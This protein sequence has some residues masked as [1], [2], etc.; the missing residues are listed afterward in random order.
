MP[1][2]GLVIGA[3]TLLSMSF[4]YDPAYTGPNV[5]G[6][7]HSH[8]TT[9]SG[10]LFWK[11]TTY[12]NTADYAESKAVTTGNGSVSVSGTNLN[13]NAITGQKVQKSGNNTNDEAVLT[14]NCGY[15]TND[16]EGEDNELASKHSNTVTFTAK[17]DPG[18]QFS[19]WKDNGGTRLS[20][21]NPC[22][23][24][25]TMGISDYAS[26]KGSATN[27]PSD[28]KY[29]STVYYAD[30]TPITITAVSVDR[31]QAHVGDSAEGYAV[32]TISSTKATTADFN[33]PSF[34][35][36]IAGDWEVT[37]WLV[38]NGKI[39]VNYRF[40]P[41]VQGEYDSGVTLTV[42]S[43]AGKS[44]DATIPV[45]VNPAATK[46]YSRLTAKLSTKSAYDGGEIW[47]S[48]T[49]GML[50]VDWST[51]D[52]VVSHISYKT[53][54]TI[55]YYLH[56]QS[57]DPNKYIFV[58]WYST[59]AC[60][61]GDLLSDST[62]YSV[63]ITPTSTD[64]DAPTAQTVYARF[65]RLSEHY[66]EVTALPNKAGLG[67]VYATET[68][69]NNPADSLYSPSGSQAMC[70]VMSTST[71]AV[72]GTIYVHAYP[73]Y[74]YKFDGWFTNAACTGA[75]VSTNAHYAYSAEAVST[76]PVVPTKKTLYAKFSM[77]TPI[78]VTFNYPANG[79]Y[80]A[81]VR[82][83]VVED[84]EYVWGEVQIYNSAEQ[85][86]T[87][88]QQMYPTGSIT[89]TATPVAGMAVKSWTDGSSTVTS[90]S[91]NYTTTVT[92]AKT[93]GVTMGAA[94]P[95]SVE[96]T[97]YSD[98]HD[99][100][101]AAG[102]T[103]TIIVVEDCWIPAGDYTIP[104]G[105]SLLIPDAADNTQIKKS[106]TISSDGKTAPTPF[107][108]V[109]MGPGAE[110]ILEG[111]LG[112]SGTQSGVSSGDPGAGAVIGGYGCLDMSKGGSITVKSTGKLYAFGII[113]GAGN[114]STSGTITVESGGE[115]YE[116]IVIMDLHGGGGTAAIVNGTTAKNHYGVFPFNQFY[117]QNI[118]PRMTLQSGAT[119]KVYYYIYA[120]AGASGSLNFI[121]NTNDSFFEISN[122]S[123]S[124]TK[125]Y[126]YTTDRQ[127]YEMNGN[128]NINA[129]T[130]SINFILTS[131]NITSSDFILP[132]GN[133]DFTLTEGA[134]MTLTND[135]EMLPGARITIAQ[136]ANLTIAKSLYLYDY[137]DW[138]L[139]CATGYVRPI[140]TTPEHKTAADARTPKDASTYSRMGQAE[141]VI[142]G[143]VTVKANGRIYT[144]SGGANIYSHGTGKLIYSTAVP[145][146]GKNLYK[147]YKH[148]GRSTSDALTAEEA[149]DG[150]KAADGQTKIG[151]FK[152]L[153]KKYGA[154]ADAIPCTPAVL[155]NA[156]GS[157]YQTAGKTAGTTV[158]YVNGY[159][160]VLTVDSCLYRDE[161]G[162]IYTFTDEDD[163][164]EVI[165]SS[166]Y[167]K[168][169]EKVEASN[170]LFIHTANNCDWVKV[171]AVPEVALT[172]KLLKDPETN[173]Y[174]QYN[175][176]LDYWEEATSYTVTFKNY[177]NKVLQEDKI[178]PGGVPAY[179]GLSNPVHPDDEIGV[180][181]FI[182]WKVNGEGDTITS[183]SAVNAN[184][185]YIAQYSHTPNVAKVNSL[186]V[187]TYY[188][189]WASAL[190]AVN[191]QAT[192]PTLKLLGDV[193]G[194][195]TEQTISQSMTLDLNGH[196]LS[197]TVSEML[198]VNS[199]IIVTIKDGSGGKTGV[200]SSVGTATSGNFYTMSVAKGKVILENGTL[201]GKANGATV[202]PILIETSGS[203]EME[204]GRITT[205]ATGTNNHGMLVKTKN[206]FI[207]GGTIDMPGA[208]V[209]ISNGYSEAEKMTISGGYIKGGTII[210][211]ENSADTRV[212]VTGGY[213][214]TDA[215]LD[216]LV[217]DSYH[218]LDNEEDSKT[219]YP[220]TVAQ[221]YHV[222]FKNGETALQ[223]GYVKVGAKPA[224][225]G[226]IPTKDADAQYTYA[227]K[228]WIDN[229]LVEY[230]KDATLPV[231]GDADVTY[232][233]TFTA[234]LKSYTLA[235]DLNG[236]SVT[237]SGT[238][239]GSVAFGTSLTA[240][241][242]ERTGYIFKGWSPTV[243]ATMPAKD[244][245][246]TA[247]W[248]PAETGDYLDIVDWTENSL[249]INTNALAASGWP[250]TINDVEY[251]KTA[252]LEDRTLIIPYSGS[253]DGVLDITVNNKNSE[254]VSKRSY[255]IPHIYDTDANLSGVNENS[256]V[257][258]H[259]GAIVTVATNTN[260][261]AI[262][263]APN[264]D[265]VVSNGFTLTLADKLV[266]RTTPWAAAALDNRGTISG[267]QVYYSY[268]IANKDQQYYQFAMP[269]A[270]NTNNVKTS[271]DIVNNRATEYPYNTAWLMKYY[272]E[273][274]R[275]NNGATGKNWVALAPGTI[276]GTVGYELFSMSK[277]YREYY[278]PI[279][280][281][282]I[283]ATTVTVQYT[284]GS[285][286]A[287]NGWNAV[288]SPMTKEFR[289]VFANPSKAVKVSELM[290]DGRYYQHIPTTIRPAVP[291]YYQASQGQTQLVFGSEMTA[292]APYRAIDNEEVATEWLQVHYSDA[293]G[294][295]D[296][297]N[298]FLHP[299]DFVAEYENGLD[300]A[301]LS[302]TGARPFLYTSLACGDL[303]F[304][305]L[306]DEAAQRIPL[307]VYSPANGAYT[308]SLTDN[309]YMDRMDA[310]YLVDEQMGIYTDLLS[311]G[312]YSVAVEQGTTTG[313]FYLMA[314]FA[315]APGVAT[316]MDEAEG[317]ESMTIEKVFIDGLF[318]IRRGGE[319][320]DL[321][322]RLVK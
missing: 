103:K 234:T 112:L 65:I 276:S 149:Y 228:G 135:V 23:E 190:A 106:P 122:D 199:A 256:I 168:A 4:P 120:Q 134:N 192:N 27:Y 281:P 97:T 151:D 33:T 40:L 158:R 307:T 176:T 140:T 278:F 36:T 178:Y 147:I 174:Y 45:T 280:L 85:T 35:A 129:I 152:F 250:Y 274:S 139:Y 196:T 285:N 63:D 309:D 254:T 259:S 43:K 238:A 72:N 216:L 148:Y 313:R 76:D 56:A 267:G 270:S 1:L 212:N 169:W 269:L 170:V 102:S 218:I 210:N 310:V 227:F 246:Y 153:N 48:K 255:T 88:T 211:S 204:G 67:M 165:A 69:G 183:F 104:N 177:N 46:Y 257:Y 162:H 86:D 2:I 272:S 220:Y 11:E 185:T 15:N 66:L 83:V 290:E 28:N 10:I 279:T 77:A 260:V 286:A 186:G 75:A 145:V 70:E 242:V 248:T 207:K 223:E 74:G 13:S 60:A 12:H 195:S 214:S 32:F 203:F 55:T 287:D 73:K 156:N 121:S 79:T 219:T 133:F 107:R 252:R 62:D 292:S 44:A 197:G 299:T 42:V 198:K 217:A 8:W 251:Q 312:T 263:V 124:I 57:K 293:Q 306:P 180:Y 215:S 237:T 282:D 113:T 58:G 184:T 231:V 193:S 284:N 54:E 127:C 265:L 304:A 96:G 6:P 200:I 209:Y 82:D 99:A 52:Q 163:F 150:T 22:V 3:F 26:N 175:S 25:F 131:I 166:T 38:G 91:V 321:N 189:T 105:V 61:L 143:T 247:Q 239:A 39:K 275:A 295:S 229:N 18:Y 240:P 111:N 9:T 249:T 303:A 7:K 318:Y 154:Y 283:Q 30:F 194:I 320:Y 289:Q 128:V 262:Y 109:V 114:E 208:A 244:E 157:V 51:S 68:A 136:G 17:P 273:Y 49:E 47:A 300:V 315:P 311:G 305:A 84:G 173:T 241:K 171:N 146:D 144:T 100:I 93:L 155:R 81:S 308:F 191:S 181:T 16:Q 20:T 53:P 243:P 222:T 316:G 221:A 301:K 64:A 90:G 37:E 167:T 92:A 224:Y 319:L 187:T 317:A 245:T 98:L 266:L 271:D 80:T 188:T 94:S 21:D 108:R 233:A 87:I 261:K 277:Y 19:E 116:D 230:D 31:V 226:K 130:L 78:N 101:A 296:E 71:A 206:T 235:W 138:G 205:D 34:T 201:K 14:W 213:F 118:E 89:L 5:S 225:T 160:K 141:M 95:F 302:T 202:F 179:K 119:E 298:I 125:W 110:I 142:D 29:Q 236:G 314:E 161:L 24:T 115:V 159:W 164:T 322:G 137:S 291:F 132:I 41:T 182:G 294:R 126:D 268:I 172:T 288:C 123:S 258:I 253:A 50:G 297:T 59:D 264:A 232:T 117:V